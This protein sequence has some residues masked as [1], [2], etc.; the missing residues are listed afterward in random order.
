MR[1]IILDKRFFSGSSSRRFETSKMMEELLK[2]PKIS[3]ALYDR[4]RQREF[5]DAVM[6]AMGRESE[7]DSDTLRVVLKNLYNGTSHITKGGIKDIASAMLLENRDPSKEY[8]V[9]RGIESDSEESR[10]TTVANDTAEIQSAQPGTDAE[11]PS[12]TTI[13]KRTV[14]QRIF[15]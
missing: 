11:N 6:R 2:H 1:R 9:K 3:R 8:F 4:A 15:G 7:L 14:F 13:P 12:E 10:P 5:H